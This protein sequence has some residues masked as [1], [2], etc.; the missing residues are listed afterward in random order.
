MVALGL[1]SGCGS[2]VASKP[3]PSPLQG[4]EVREYKGEKL[5]AP[6]D[7]H[8]N[9]IKGPQHVDSIKYLLT[10]AGKAGHE[11]VYT[12]RQVIDSFA[13]YSKVVTL[14]CVEGWQVKIL[15][16]GVLVRDLLASAGIDSSAKIVIFTAADGYTT[17]LPLD[18]V[19]NNNI[20]L[21]YNMNGA[22]LRPERGFPFELVAEDKWGYK[23]IKWVAKIELSD[24]VNYQGY[25]ERRGYSNDG[26][27]KKPFY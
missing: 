5:G 20:M 27:L 23:W 18:Y 17:S 8:E 22:P 12:Y 6:G 25:W 13:H 3:S 24:N 2:R 11:R 10:V 1:L 26:D 9:S 21:A 4:V 7:F 19:L 16:D 15:W 14:Y